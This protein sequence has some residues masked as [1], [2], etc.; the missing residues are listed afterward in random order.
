MRLKF[1]KVN[2]LV[3]HFCAFLIGASLVSIKID[4]GAI[5]KNALLPL[6]RKLI[7]SN[8][9]H[10]WRLTYGNLEK[11]CWLAR[12]LRAIPIKDHW[13]VPVSMNTINYAL[14]IGMGSTSDLSLE[15]DDETKREQ[16]HSDVRVYVRTIR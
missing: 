6:D 10:R 8:K 16:C 14:E 12:N 13:F 9:T 7:E 4:F 5:G 15:G 2:P 11:R 3:S 1:P